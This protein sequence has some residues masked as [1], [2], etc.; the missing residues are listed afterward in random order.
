MKWCNLRIQLFVFVQFHSCHHFKV[1]IA[2]LLIATL[3]CMFSLLWPN[4]FKTIIYYCLSYTSNLL[5]YLIKNKFLYH[6]M[7]VHVLGVGL[8]YIV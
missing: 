5:V 3:F 6:S 4:D 8:V 7:H 2:K 1:L